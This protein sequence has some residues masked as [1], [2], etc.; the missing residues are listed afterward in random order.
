M[1]VLAVM[2][3]HYPLGSELTSTLENIRHIL[4][5]PLRKGLAGKLIAE[6]GSSSAPPS[7]APPGY[8]WKKTTVPRY[9]WKD[10]TD[11]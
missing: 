2:A 6:G 10:V 11:N 7:T 4:S 1:A 9:G 5:N 8:Y 3:K